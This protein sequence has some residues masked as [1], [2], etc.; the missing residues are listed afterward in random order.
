[1]M[2]HG[3]RSSHSSLRVSHPVGLRGKKAIG[4]RAL[5]ILVS[6][7]IIALLIYGFYAY[8]GLRGS[9]LESK[10]SVTMKGLEQSAELVSLL[11][12]PTGAAR[13]L[14]D[15]I[16]EGKDVAL[17]VKQTIDT[18]FGESTKYKLSV[19]DKPIAQ[20]A[21]EPLA[22]SVQEVAIPDYAG[23]KILQVKLVIER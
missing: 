18:V 11:R 21:N 15:E 19:D 4:G 22:T 14:A 8:Y 16:A 12:T 7:G 13:N 17:K 5:N 10:I 3:K 23:D 20:S 1:M 6:I 9:S 2:L